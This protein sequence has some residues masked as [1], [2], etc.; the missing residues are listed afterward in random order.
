MRLVQTYAAKLHK[1][2]LA[3]GEFDRFISIAGEFADGE[4]LKLYHTVASDAS[5]ERRVT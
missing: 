5:D 3:K 1:L 4:V 2:L